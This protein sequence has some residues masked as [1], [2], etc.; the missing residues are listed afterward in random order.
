M[1]VRAE[2][3]RRVL[4][5]AY[6]RPQRPRAH[7][8]S[9]MQDLIDEGLMQACAINGQSVKLMRELTPKGRAHVE[10]MLMPMAGLS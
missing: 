8:K 6:S 5:A 2:I 1:N 4:I 7:T 9:I 10:R 3:R